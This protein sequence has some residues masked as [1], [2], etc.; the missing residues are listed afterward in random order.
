MGRLVLGIFKGGLVGA[1]IGY[2]ASRA[3]VATGALAFLVYAVIGGAVGLVCGRPLWRQDT[4][5]TPVLKVLFGVGIGVGAGFLG[6]SFLSNVYLPIEAIPEA[7]KRPVPE[8]PAIFGTV[9]G[10]LY[11]AFVE[12]DDAGSGGADAAAKKT[13]R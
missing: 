2:L 11:G 4:I 13:A 5:W 10:I 9:I 7:L 12:I 3:G 8:V 1:G 6:R